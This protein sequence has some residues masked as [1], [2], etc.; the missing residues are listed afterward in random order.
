MLLHSAL[1]CAETGRF[2][3]DVQGAGELP[4]VGLGRLALADEDHLSAVASSEACQGKPFA[5]VAITSWATAPVPE[6][7]PV[8]S[9]VPCSVTAISW[10]CPTIWLDW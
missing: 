3:G 6:I 1:Y 9:S 7:T 5:L 4:V 10:V 8:T 2:A